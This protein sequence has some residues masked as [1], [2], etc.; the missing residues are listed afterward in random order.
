MKSGGSRLKSV[1]SQ[2]M[3][4]MQTSGMHFGSM[5]R[6]KVSWPA[7]LQTRETDPAPEH[8][9]QMSMEGFLYLVVSYCDFHARKHVCEA[10]YY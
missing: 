9:S 6:V 5:S 2:D 4:S 1:Y 8:M 7:P 3:I 10:R